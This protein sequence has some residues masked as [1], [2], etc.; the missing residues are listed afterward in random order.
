MP[1]IAQESP[2]VQSSRKR[3]RDGN[4]HQIYP[5]T[6]TPHGIFDQDDRTHHSSALANRKIIPIPP[7]KRQ[8]TLVDIEFEVDG[9]PMQRSPSNSPPQRH[10]HEFHHPHRDHQQTRDASR[11]EEDTR[12]RSTVPPLS[13]APS[14]SRCHIC[15]RKPNKKSDLDSFADCQ[16]CGQRTCY[17]C[18]REC[19]GWGGGGDGD[20]G[21]GPSP[22]SY[23]HSITTT[24]TQTQQQPQ[25]RAQPPHP[26]V[27]EGPH[28]SARALPSP[29]AATTSRPRGGA[30]A[31][32]AGEVSFT[33]LDADDEEQQAQHDDIGRREREQ[34]WTTG[35]GHRRVVCSRCCVER[36]QDGEVVCLGC[37]PFVEG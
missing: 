6:N 31:E 1:S 14:M 26:A 23:A 37:L 20:G 8:R 10:H 30:S 32:E 4:D 13:A 25:P 28:H 18:I 36:G 21:G 12:S 34:G 3:R 15:S 7:G 35:G 33:M 19:L 11:V 29:P 16:G 27:S 24:R 9:E 2:T 17:V 5:A 22:S